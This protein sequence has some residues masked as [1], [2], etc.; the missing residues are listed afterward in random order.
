MLYIWRLFTCQS[1][2]ILSS[3]CF[4]DCLCNLVRSHH[5]DIVHSVVV[6]LTNPDPRDYSK[7]GDPRENQARWDL[8]ELVLDE[9]CKEHIV[10]Y[11][12]TVD[13]YYKRMNS[14]FSKQVCLSY[15][16]FIVYSVFIVYVLMLLCFPV[17][18][19]ATEGCSDSQTWSAR[20]A[21]YL[22]LYWRWVLQR[23]SFFQNFHNAQNL[24]KP[25]R[26]WTAGMG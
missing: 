8:I 22:V 16:Y 15:I 17:F 11:F 19:Y 20:W 3:H 21:V 14:C 9:C 7:I 24:D 12:S 13:A 4:S 5:G 25:G 1:K 10:E 26:T 2:Y 23:D 18:F 6:T